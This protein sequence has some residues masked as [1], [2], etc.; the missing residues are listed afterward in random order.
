MD[1]G[2]YGHRHGDITSAATSKE[3]QNQMNEREKRA[4]VVLD[5][6]SGVDEVVE[7]NPNKSA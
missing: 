3:S 1:C 5:G 2:D 7:F 6:Q 4:P